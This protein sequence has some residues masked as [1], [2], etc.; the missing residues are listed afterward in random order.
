MEVIDYALLAARGVLAGVFL[1]AGAAKLTSSKTV[2][3][4]LEFGVPRPLR[5]LLPWLPR[6]E[7]VVGLGF[8][9]A[10]TTWYAA[11]AALALLSIFILG[12]AAN[13]VR[14]RRPPCNCFGQ[15]HPRPI[16]WWTIVRNGALAAC[17]GWLIAMGP[18][19]ARADLWTFVMA[20]EGQ[21]RLGAFLVAVVIA[22]GI[23]LLVRDQEEDETPL[24]EL[25]MPTVDEMLGK[26]PA[27]VA[28]TRAVPAAA[29]R[30]ERVAPE[31]RYAAPGIV[32]NGD[33][34]PAGMTAPGFELPD[35]YGQ[36]HSLATLL[37]EGKP[38]VLIFTSPHCESCQ[39]LVPRLPPLAAERADAVRLVLISKGSPDQVLAKIKEPGSL[40]VLLQKEY[41]VAESFNS[42]TSPA[43]V[44]VAPDGS[45]DSSLATGGPAVLELVDETRRS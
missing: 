31:A 32:L 8:L 21:K 42:T 13:L 37:G 36:T 1:V 22:V 19:P 43:A 40:L 24:A 35:V 6:I 28:T 16:S 44:R 23:L 11:W 25:D 38:L 30:R 17:A 10:V 15:I 41:E 27:A 12:I 14:G 9:F 34:L 4:L 5:P 20:L 2:Q 26:T 39:W 45:I 29:P 33:G 3:A 18:P 7:I